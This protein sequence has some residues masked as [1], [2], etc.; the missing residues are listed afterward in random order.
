MT[1]HP[2]R[3]DFIT[4]EYRRKD[5]MKQAEK[6]LL[7]RVAQN[8]ASDQAPIHHRMLMGFGAWLEQLGR[9]LKSHY[10]EVADLEIQSTALS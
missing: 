6:E 1:V 9:R 10:V 3:R 4:N 5:M 8:N 7:I 2:T